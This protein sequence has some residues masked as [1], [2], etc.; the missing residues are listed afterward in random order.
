MLCSVVKVFHELDLTIVNGLFVHVKKEVSESVKGLISKWGVKTCRIPKSSQKPKLP[1]L[2][3]KF[4]PKLHSLTTDG[5][6]GPLH[7]LQREHHHPDRSNDKLLKVIH[8]K[9]LKDL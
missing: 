6:C 4:I 7:I 3:W 8:L 9:R 1:N 2:S 5:F